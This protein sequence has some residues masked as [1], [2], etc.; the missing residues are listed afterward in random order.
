MNKVEL[1]R[2]LSKNTEFKNKDCNLLIDEMVNIIQGELAQGNRVQI[3]GFGYFDVQ[4]RKS[5]K[6]VNPRTKEAMQIP[7]CRCACFKSGKTLRETLNAK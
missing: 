3:S 2:Q 1:A 7:A 6:G 5:R 4:N